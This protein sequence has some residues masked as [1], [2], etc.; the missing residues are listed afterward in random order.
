MINSLLALLLLHAPVGTM[1]IDPIATHIVIGDVGAGANSDYEPTTDASAYLRCSPGEPMYI[2]SS[3][4][5]HGVTIPEAT[6]PLGL[7]YVDCPS[8][9][10][11]RYQTEFGGPTLRPGLATVSFTVHRNYDANGRVIARATSIVL[12]PR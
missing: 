6:G 7:G 10:I 12:V 4:R 5:Q 3:M 8:N 11:L 2:A 9:G 1:V